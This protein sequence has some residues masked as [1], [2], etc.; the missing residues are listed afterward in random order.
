MQKTEE[1]KHDAN[2]KGGGCDDRHEEIAVET[3]NG[4]CGIVRRIGIGESQ[5]SHGESG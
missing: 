3:P 1:D 2:G 5:F 4:A